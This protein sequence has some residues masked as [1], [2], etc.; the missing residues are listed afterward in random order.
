ML[1]T[2]VVEH[3]WNFARTIPHAFDFRSCIKSETNHKYSS[4][5]SN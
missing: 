2:S 3:I 4:L 1:E 5:I